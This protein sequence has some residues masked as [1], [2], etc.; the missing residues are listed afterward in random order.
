[1]DSGFHGV[2]AKFWPNQ[3]NVAA[4]WDPSDQPTFVQCSV[5]QYLRAGVVSISC[6]KLAPAVVSCCCSPSSSRLD[7]LC[8]Q[9]WYSS[10][11]GCNRLLF[12]LL[13]FYHLSSRINEAFLSTHLLFNGQF[14]FFGPFSKCIW[15]LCGPEIWSQS[16]SFVSNAVFPC[17][18]LLTR[19]DTGYSIMSFDC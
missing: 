7:A 9:R 12:Q 3:L 15:V 17:Q 6:C 13:S 11:L 10:S 14:L 19:A 2:C 1:M 18:S 16:Q 4:N 5:G 8:C